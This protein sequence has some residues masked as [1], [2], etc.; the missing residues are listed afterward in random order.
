M[1]HFRISVFVVMKIHFSSDTQTHMNT[2][3][4][5]KFTYLRLGPL[6]LMTVDLLRSL[7][8][9]VSIDGR[10]DGLDSKGNE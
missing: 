10:L 5:H 4:T 9:Q 3:T 6:L 2:E 7:K 8:Q 1:G